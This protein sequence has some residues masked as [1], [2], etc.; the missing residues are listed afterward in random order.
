[1]PT[2]SIPSGAYTQIVAETVQ[3]LTGDPTS[4]TP[5]QAQLT[6]W[7]NAKVI[8]L[9]IRYP[10]I[11]TTDGS[12]TTLTANDLSEFYVAVG[13]L[14]AAQYCRT[15][16]GSLLVSQVVETSVG[17]VTRKRSQVMLG[18][19]WRGFNRDAVSAL[20]RI[21]L[22]GNSIIGDTVSKSHIHH[23]ETVFDQAFVNSHDAFDT[24]TDDD[25][26]EDEIDQSSSTWP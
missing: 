9:L 3:A 16:A 18:D 23:P 24:D 11:A 19:V 22:I 12:W 5:S 4:A 2:L 8:G 25:P 20:R 6:R 21:S 17:P 26:G 7:I 15:P 10:Q 14:V 13:N 1:M